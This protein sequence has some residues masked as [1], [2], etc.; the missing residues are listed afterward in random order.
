[1]MGVSEYLA[2]PRPVF[3]FLSILRPEGPAQN[4]WGHFHRVIE[5]F[6]FVV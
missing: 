6:N 1:M 5:L 4:Y 2:L 3:F